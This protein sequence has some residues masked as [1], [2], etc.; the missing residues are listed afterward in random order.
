MKKCNCE[1]E[2]RGGIFFRGICLFFL[3]CAG[4][5]CPMQVYAGEAAFAKEG[6]VYLIESAADLRQLAVLVNG[7]EEVEP[8]VPANTASYLL[9]R[10]IDI[11]DYCTQEGGWEPI[12]WCEEITSGGKDSV[13]CSVDD[14][15]QFNGVFDGGGH[16]ITGLYINRPEAMGQG[17]FGLSRTES[18]FGYPGDVE[19]YLER[20]RT[21]IRNLYLEDCDV[22]GDIYVGGVIGWMWATL[23]YPNGEVDIENCHVT[24]KVQGK[25]CGGIGGRIAMAK[26]CSFS[27]IVTSPAGAGGIAAQARHIEGCAFH[28]DVEGRT[29]V[30]GLA[31]EAGCVRNSYAVGTVTGYKKVGGIVGSG[32][33]LTGCYTRADVA[34][35]DDTGGL[36]GIVYSGTILSM[37]GE[38]AQPY[39]EVRNCLIGAQQDCSSLEEKDF[40]DILSAPGQT[41]EDVWLCA[42][43]GA[44]PVLKWET[45]SRFG[46]ETVYVVREGDCLSGI[47]G[48]IFARVGYW[49]DIYSD[50]RDIIGDD[51]DIILPGTELRIILERR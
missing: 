3:C 21:V 33:C 12:G 26:N 43:D 49:P 46:Y 24:G 5:F 16:V 18:W 41:W 17:L 45:H 22:T 1:Y 28:G 27:G 13:I 35:H 36:A 14:T 7:E 4:I 48:Q 19:Y 50:N 15:R 42:A 11:S 9:T 38:H 47:A 25:L 40:R 8:G 30:G 44:W 37:E 32:I 34:G 31:G 51:P 29:Y 2:K 6:D 23:E 39:E 20:K 10:D